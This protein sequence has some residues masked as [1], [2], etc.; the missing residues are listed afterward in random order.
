VPPDPLQFVY[1]Y[2]EREDREMAARNAAALACGRVRQIE[3][4]LTQLFARMDPDDLVK[5]DFVLS[6]LGILEDC[7]G[8]PCPACEACELRCLC[9]RRTGSLESA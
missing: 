4:S 1:R 8:R 7:S 5:Y 9:A 2:T 6:R 3:R